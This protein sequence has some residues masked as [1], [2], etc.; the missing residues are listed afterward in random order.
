MG[1][2]IVAARLCF[3][4][5]LG[6]LLIRYR[7][8]FPTWLPVA[9]HLVRVTARG[10]CGLLDRLVEKSKRL[11]EPNRLG[12]LRDLLRGYIVGCRTTRTGPVAVMKLRDPETGE[13]LEVTVE[14]DDA[15]PREVLEDVAR[16]LC[17]GAG[18]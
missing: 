16:S 18:G 17:E 12:E 8:W 2:C 15:A 9:P 10:D 7:V 1:A 3:S 11:L 6:E 4:G 13:S 5:S 14:S